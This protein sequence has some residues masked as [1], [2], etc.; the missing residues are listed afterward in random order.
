LL[1]DILKLFGCTGACGL[2]EV[3]EASKNIEASSRRRRPVK[4]RTSFLVLVVSFNVFMGICSLEFYLPMTLLS[5][6]K[7]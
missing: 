6:N 7:L 2:Q 4:D 3:S 5:K 1:V